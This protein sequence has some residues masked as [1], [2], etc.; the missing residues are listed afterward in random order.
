M[1]RTALAIFIALFLSAI[2]YSQEAAPEK[3]E[4]E[5]PK[6]VAAP[7]VTPEGDVY[8]EIVVQDFE[9]IQFKE[10]DIIFQRSGDEEY[11]VTIRD[12]F[13]APVNNSKKYL[14]VKLRGSKK[15]A[16]QIKF[17]A[18]KI[19]TINQYCQSISM[20]VYGKR[21][22]GELSLFILDADGQAH[23]LSFGKLNFHGWHK[24][25]R[26]LPQNINQNDSFLET[27]SNIKILSILY[28]P[29]TWFKFG[30]NVIDPEWQTFYIDDITANVRAKYKDS[31]SDDW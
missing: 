18:D 9:N 26:T 24:I 19:P 1:K 11:K 16:I 4:Q 25:K 27:N 6:E 17:P 5:A 21:F 23:K 2:S 31:Q 3:P 13:P 8:Q 7:V 10:S 14:G 15:N 30:T 22:T 28:V 12:E 29:G 20:W